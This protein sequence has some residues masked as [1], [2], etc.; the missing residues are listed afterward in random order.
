MNIV[1]RSLRPTFLRKKGSEIWDREVEFPA[2]TLINI[3]APSGKGKTSLV[4]IL[5]GLLKDYRG[6]LHF[7]HQDIS[8]LGRRQWALLRQRHL[9][10]VFQD[11]RLFSHLTCLENVI[12]NAGQTGPADRDRIEAAFH[13]LGVQD[14]QHVSAGRCSQGEQQRIAFIRA[15]SQP[16]SW[17]F[18]DEPFSHLDEAR[19]QA[20]HD[21]LLDACRRTRGGVILTSLEAS[22]LLPF[23]G[24]YSL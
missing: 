9:S 1:I 20:M 19:V 13:S 6:S 8:C 7:D 22:T 18:L 24:T 2:G 4:S 12:L 21:L 23:H 17:I 16:F 11:L 15:I 5:Y 3:A 10:L 14:L